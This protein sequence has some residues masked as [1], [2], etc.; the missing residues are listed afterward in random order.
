MDTPVGHEIS[1]VHSVI[2]R[3]SNPQGHAWVIEDNSSMNGT[4]VNLKKVQ[5]R[6]L[7]SGDEI[8]FGGGPNFREGDFLESAEKAYCRYFFFTLDPVVR[9]SGRLDPNAVLPWPGAD[10]LCSICYAPMQSPEALPCGHVFCLECI[11]RWAETC[12][13]SCRNIVCPM[14]RNPFWQSQLRRCETRFVS[15]EL[16]VLS[17]EGML[18]DL[19]VRSCRVIKS[20]NIFKT[21]NG[22]HKKWFWRWFEQVVGNR[23]RRMIFLHLTKATVGCILAAST[24]DLAQALVNFELDVP[25]NQN[26]MIRNLLLFVLM[27]L[28]PRKK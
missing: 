27:K 22:H 12:I 23:D 14:C 7:T 25:E 5:R 6:L 11:Q 2:H 10:E 17:V 18:R 26:E 16:E 28:I 21:W 9:F 13:A 4:F 20:V 19:N 3:R 8:V 1:K 24:E 15:G